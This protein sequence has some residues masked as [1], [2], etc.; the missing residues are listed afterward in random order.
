MQTPQRVIIYIIIM[1]VCVILYKYGNKLLVS[2]KKR[3]TSKSEKK[4]EKQ[5]PLPIEAPPQNTTLPLETQEPISDADLVKL[6]SNNYED[7]DN[8]SL[9]KISIDNM[10]KRNITESNDSDKFKSLYADTI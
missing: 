2:G 9:D 3:K 8:I 4:I 7:H 6:M 10:S 1:F 5:Q